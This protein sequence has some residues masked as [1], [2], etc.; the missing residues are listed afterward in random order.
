MTKTTLA[1]FAVAGLALIDASAAHATP[2]QYTW[3]GFYIGGE[4]G[5]INRNFDFSGGFTGSAS[6]TNFFGGVYGG[7]NYQLPNNFVI[8][9]EARFDFMNAKES[10]GA[11]DVRSNWTDSVVA[12]G[13]Y[14]ING[15]VMPF[16]SVGG[17][18]MNQTNTFPSISADNTRSGW[19]VGGGVE[20]RNLFGGTSPLCRSLVTRA[21]YRYADYGSFINFGD[22]H[23]KTTTNAFMLGF[24]TKISKWAA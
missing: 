14:V 8:G 24:S 16:V 4:V 18:W 19:T 9:A 6:P 2:P 5:G 11:L 10:I 7:Y 23:A 12:R 15:S 17:S 13:G 1:S 20:V 21:E 3:T 22:L